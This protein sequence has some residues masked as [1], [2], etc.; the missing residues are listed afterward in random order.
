MTSRVILFLGAPGSGK[1]TQSSWLSSKLGIPSLSTGDML[2]AAAKENTPAGLHLREIL[3]SGLLVSDSIVCDAVALRLRSERERGMILDGFPR[4]V[5]QA[6]CLDQILTDLKLPPPLVLHLDIS[7]ERLLDRLTARRQCAACGA[8]YNLLSRPSRAGTRC[9]NDGGK[10][11]QRDDDSESVIMRRFVEF[12]AA[13]EPLVLHYS[14]ANYYRID[15]DRDPAL[16][17]AEL[18][19]ITGTARRS[20][21]A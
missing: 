10:L 12:N 17:S 2:R 18:L 21:A 5:G 4:T 13:C 1:G 16:I 6:R 20:V 3:A 15:G 9:E 14:K 7:P 11:L 19:R 8:I